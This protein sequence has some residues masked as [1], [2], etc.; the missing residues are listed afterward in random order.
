MLLLVSLVL[1]LLVVVVVGAAA[2]AVRP[3]CLLDERPACTLQPSYYEPMA[4]C[5]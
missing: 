5:L 4:L 3:H 2:A 1:L